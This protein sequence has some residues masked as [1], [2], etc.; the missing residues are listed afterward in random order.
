MR[1]INGNDGLGAHGWPDRP[2]WGEP[3]GSLRQPG[4]CDHRIVPLR[5]ASTEMPFSVRMLPMARS[6]AARALT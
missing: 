6:S 3:F 4:D 5:A 2:V 1:V